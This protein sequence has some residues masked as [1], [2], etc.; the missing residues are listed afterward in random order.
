GQA[1]RINNR[2]FLLS[3]LASTCFAAGGL[4]HAQAQDHADHDMSAG[5]QAQGPSAVQDGLWSDP[6][7]WGGAVPA[8]GDAVTIGEGMDVVL[9]VSTAPLRGMNLDGTLSFSDENDVELTTEWVLLRGA[10]QAGS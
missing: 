2:A 10:L 7:T 8:G 9:D 6:S 4:A 3:L 1:M 5:A